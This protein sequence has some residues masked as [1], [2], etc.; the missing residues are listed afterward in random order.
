MRYSHVTCRVRCTWL[1]EQWLVNVQDNTICTL[2]HVVRKCGIASDNLL[3]GLK[4]LM[5]KGAMSLEHCESMVNNCKARY[6]CGGALGSKGTSVRVIASW[7][8]LDQVDCAIGYVNV[9]S[10]TG[11]LI[12]TSMYGL[13]F[14]VKQ[15]LLVFCNTK[16]WTLGPE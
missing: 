3:E 14:L 5:L 7:L 15:E 13:L 12:R 4:R 11:Y 6:V 10:D 16:R 1:W 9:C 2:W 8:S